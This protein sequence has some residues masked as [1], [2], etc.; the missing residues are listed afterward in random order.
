MATTT[1]GQIYQDVRGILS[2]TQIASGEWFP[3]SYYAQATG[4]PG[5]FGEPYR[6]MFSKLAGGSKRVQRV[7]Y[8]VLPPSTN[9]VIPSTYNIVD[10]AEPEMIE[11]RPAPSSIVVTATSTTTPIAVTA[12]SHGLGGAGSIAEG[13]LSGIAGTQSPWGNWFVTVVDADHFTLNGSASDGVAGTGGFFYPM[14][15][16]QFTEVTPLDLTAGGL[17]GQ[18]SQVLGCYLWI[19][20]MLQFRGATSAVQL[21]ITYYASGTAPTDP[22]YVISIDDCRDFLS[23]ATAANCARAKQWWVMAESLQSRA[24]GDPTHPETPSLLDLFYAKQ[25]MA[26]QR[27]PSRRQGPFRNRKSKIGGYL[28]G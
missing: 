1:L 13:A 6:S 10:F 22:N 9:V 11:E 26:D 12:P 18:A 15:S 23:I 21:R 2:D 19:N 27:G 3:N 28:I 14:S 4:N 20:E 5:A 17:D 16:Q 25:V 8:I 7:V 24:Y